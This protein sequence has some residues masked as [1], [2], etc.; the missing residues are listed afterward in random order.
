LVLGAPILP[1]T[2]TKSEPNEASL[3]KITLQ[4][5]G[6]SHVD[7]G[8]FIP[9]FTRFLYILLCG[10]SVPVYGPTGTF[11][12]SKKVNFLEL[13]STQIFPGNFQGHFPEY[14]SIP[15]G[16]MFSL[17]HPGKAYPIKQKT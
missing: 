7:A 10:K 14:S 3:W 11:Y 8:T 4:E 1:H 13:S 15:A 16:R 5:R 6:N 9:P 17:A 2:V 12:R